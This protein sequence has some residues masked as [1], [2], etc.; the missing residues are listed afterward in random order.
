MTEFNYMG[1]YGTLDRF[2]RLDAGFSRDPFALAG[3]LLAYIMASFRR[4]GED[5][6]RVDELDHDIS[7]LILAFGDEENE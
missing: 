7:E 2:I 5:A 6:E 3:A 4:A 1:L